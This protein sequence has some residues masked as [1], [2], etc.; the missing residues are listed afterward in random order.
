[1]K[2]LRAMNIKA[3]IDSGLQ[4]L[5]NRNKEVDEMPAKKRNCRCSESGDGC[6]RRPAVRRLRCRRCASEDEWQEGLH[7]Q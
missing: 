1:M 2:A 5:T 6:G 7:K 3:I 4:R